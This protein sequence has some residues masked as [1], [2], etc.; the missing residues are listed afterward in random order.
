MR[1]TAAAA[2]A[3]NYVCL[4]VFGYELMLLR[5]FKVCSSLRWNKLNQFV[6]KMV[7]IT[8]W[9]ALAKYTDIHDSV[10]ESCS[11]LSFRFT[12]F[13][14]YATPHEIVYTFS[15]LIER[16]K[17]RRTQIVRVMPHVINAF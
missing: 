9:G 15:Q 10:A 8:S 17:K 11:T 1:P 16:K 7:E 12:F 4:C 5:C 13:P 3:I 6:M 2:T 14:L